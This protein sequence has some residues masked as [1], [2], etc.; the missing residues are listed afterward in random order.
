[1]ISDADGAVSESVRLSG[2]R[3]RTIRAAVAGADPFGS[4]TPAWMVMCLLDELDRVRAQLPDGP[5]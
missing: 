1:M 3:E 5:A 2:L 4:Q